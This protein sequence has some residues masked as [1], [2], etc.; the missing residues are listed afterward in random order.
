[1]RKIIFLGC[2]GITLLFVFM[3][4]AEKNLRILELKSEGSTRNLLNFAT[5][6]L[7]PRFWRIRAAATSKM[8]TFGKDQNAFLKANNQDLN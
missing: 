2:L 4:I 8:Q 3:C 1:M 7:K 5:V 6:K